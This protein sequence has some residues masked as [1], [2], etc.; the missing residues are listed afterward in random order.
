MVDS[1]GRQR[2]VLLRTFHFDYELATAW[3]R[4]G[5]SDLQLEY[6]WVTWISRIPLRP[7]VCVEDIE[8]RVLRW[9]IYDLQPFA[10]SIMGSDRGIAPIEETLIISYNRSS[11]LAETPSFASLAS[12]HSLAQPL[13]PW[14]IVLY[15]VFVCIR[16]IDPIEIH[17]RLRIS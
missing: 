13:G 9:F 16:S 8:C 17:C 7:L 10:M 4:F 2:W 14:G 11:E 5:D 3:V 6:L 1:G 12:A 15:A